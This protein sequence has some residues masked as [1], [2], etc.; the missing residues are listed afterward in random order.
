MVEGKNLL[1]RY[2]F[3]VQPMFSVCTYES[4]RIFLIGKITVYIASAVVPW[5]FAHCTPTLL[6]NGQF[7]I[8]FPYRKI[9]YLVSSKEMWPFL[10]DWC[11]FLL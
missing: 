10:T 2:Q 5:S 6:G 4:L 1:L 7:L 9:V 3:M 11:S 8:L